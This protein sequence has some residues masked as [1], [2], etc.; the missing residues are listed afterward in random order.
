M[1]LLE[2]ALVRGSVGIGLSWF[3]ESELGDSSLILRAL[4]GLGAP[5]VCLPSVMKVFVGC[6]LRFQRRSFVA[7]ALSCEETKWTFR[8]LFVSL[9]WGDPL[10]DPLG[11]PPGDFGDWDLD[12]G[13]ADPPP[14][15][16]PGDGDR[17]RGLATPFGSGGNSQEA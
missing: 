5:R 4:V 11:D 14:F 10:G 6:C 17:P 7:A 16:S 12:L 1:T 2:R 3:V 8:F 15:L 13:L 9:S